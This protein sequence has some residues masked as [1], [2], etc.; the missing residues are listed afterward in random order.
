MALNN[1]EAIQ[2]DSRTD[3]DRADSAGPSADLAARIKSGVLRMHMAW[4]T[5]WFLGFGLLF[6]HDSPGHRTFVS[7]P[8]WLPLTVLGVLLVNAAVTTAVLGVKVFGGGRVDPR[9]AQQAKW[10]GMAWLLGFVS[11]LITI[12][13]ITHGLSSDTTGLIWGTTT[14]GLVAALHL[15][16]SA[17]WG[18][19]SQFRQ[20]LWVTLINVVGVLAGAGWQAG[21]LSVAGGAVG[22]A[23]GFRDIAR[24][25]AA[26]GAGAAAPTES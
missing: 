16:G 23:I 25:R 5:A 7:M 14:T 6:L 9:T 4:S 11:L 1:S 8:D 17:I 22:L 13:K 12:G 18:D 19:R 24:N 2:L 21:I 15:S 10:Y 3:Q 20:G 26:A